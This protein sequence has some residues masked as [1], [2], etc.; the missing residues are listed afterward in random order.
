MGKGGVYLVVDDGDVGRGGQRHSGDAADVLPQLA[1]DLQ[2]AVAGEGP[3]HGVDQVP[4]WRPPHNNN[5]N[6]SAGCQRPRDQY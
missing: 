3:E 5:N 6:S 2:T 4:L 1:S